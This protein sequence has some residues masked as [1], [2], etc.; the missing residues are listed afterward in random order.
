MRE[1][2]LTYGLTYSQNELIQNTFDCVEI[3]D[4]TGCYTDLIAIPTTAII[5]DPNLLTEQELEAFYD[6]F[7]YDDDTC[8][9]FTTEPKNVTRSLCVIEH[10]PTE[11]TDTLEVIKHRFELPNQYACA[12]RRLEGVLFNISTL[13]NGDRDLPLESKISRINNGSNIYEMITTLLENR[14]CLKIRARYPYMV[15]LESVLLSMMLAHGSIDENY[16]LN[17]ESNVFQDNEWI[18]SLSKVIK[19]HYIKT[20]ELNMN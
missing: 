13:L 16:L 15:E 20:L 14:D 6:V 1:L 19:E 12:K 5:V 10:D 7:R 11:L 18:L 3:R 4:V 17:N 2:I 9:V 8:V